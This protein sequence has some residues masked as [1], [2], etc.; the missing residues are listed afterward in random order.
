[1]KRLAENML[2]VDLGNMLLFFHD[3]DEF[4]SEYRCSRNFDRIRNR[5]SFNSIYELKMKLDMMQ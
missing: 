3:E 2:E 1:M 5:I 4:L